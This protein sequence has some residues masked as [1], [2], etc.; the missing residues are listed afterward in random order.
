VWCGAAR[1]ARPP[2]LTFRSYVTAFNLSTPNRVA[3]A[4][5][6]ADRAAASAA[7]SPATAPRAGLPPPPPRRTAFALNLSSRSLYS[8]P[9]PPPNEPRT[10][11]GAASEL[12]ALLPR[13]DAVFGNAA[14]WDALA[15]F[16]GVAE[17]SVDDDD[18]SRADQAL[19]MASD[20]GRGAAVG[21]EGGVA[22]ARHHPLRRARA[23]A[24]ALSLRPG[25][26]LVATDG[27]APTVVVRVGA[28]P[29]TGA[30]GAHEAH[31]GDRR[32]DI[33]GEGDW[34]AAAR[35]PVAVA[36]AEI[37]DTTGC[38]D[39]FVGGFLAALAHGAPIAVCV[40]AGHS[41]AEVV[42][43]ARGCALPSRRPRLRTGA[44]AADRHGGD[45]DEGNS[46]QVRPE[47]VALAAYVRG[48]RPARDWGTRAVGGWFLP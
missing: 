16:T 35:A 32:G 9:P 10:A 17:E 18:D 19:V 26:W 44:A 27:A 6:L 23:L 39:A 47:L 15:R 34:W 42:L 30:A 36:A 13:A 45:R 20:G 41:C 22:V 14:E 46:R 21:D 11:G 12:C 37:G 7:A 1:S 3:I 4:R 31:G 25:C 5:H 2:D 43:R 29:A 24:A 38:G 28:R 40:D 8:G 33:D 48:F